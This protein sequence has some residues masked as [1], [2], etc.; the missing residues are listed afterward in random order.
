MRGR[1]TLNTDGQ[2][3]TAIPMSA[4]VNLPRHAL[5]GVM[6]ALLSTFF[7]ERSA[8]A[9]YPEIMGCELG[10]S[11]VATGWPLVFVS[12]YLGMS[13]INSADIMEVWFAADRFHWLPFIADVGA[14]SCTSLLV[15]FF[16][17]KVCKTLSSRPGRL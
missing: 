15:S 4:A 12:D 11:V 5:I 7:G 10:C 13:V 6:L 17:R 8:G 14:W 3:P 1:R 9:V 16:V 2:N